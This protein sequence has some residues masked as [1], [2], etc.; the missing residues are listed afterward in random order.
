[1]FLMITH[2]AYRWACNLLYGELA[3]AYDAVSWLVSCGR[4]ANWRAVAKDYIEGEHILEVG[5]GTGELLIQLSERDLKVFGIDASPKMHAIADK[6]TRLLCKRPRLSQATARHLPFADGAFDTVVLT[7]PAEFIIET[8]VL[9]ELARVVQAKTQSS[10]TPGGRIVIVG[11]WVWLDNWMLEKALPVFYGAL[12]QRLMQA[13][14]Q[15]LEAAGMDVSFCEH[16]DGVARVGIVQA[17]VRGE[18][19]T[20]LA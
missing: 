6:K 1:M 5:F 16:V 17:A 3:W 19:P 4:W 20:V 11:L 9:H 14:R 12:D 10:D 2:H 15:P 8:S 13:I 18:R 7:F